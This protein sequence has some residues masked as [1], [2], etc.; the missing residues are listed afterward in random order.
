MKYFKLP[1]KNCICNVY[2]KDADNHT[3]FDWLLEDDDLKE[4]IINTINGQG[5]TRFD[6]IEVID[7]KIYLNTK[8]ILRVR[9]WGY[10]TGGGS[11]KL[12]A[13]EAIEEQNSV[14][15]FVAGKLRLN[16]DSI[17]QD[18]IRY[19]EDKA[20]YDKLGNYGDFYYKLKRYVQNNNS[21]TRENRD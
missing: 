13:K 10:L 18:V 20:I 2:I 8:P 15:N 17:I 9:G 6:R 21:R 1:F 7:D 11:L 3:V 19:C 14:L 5:E 12:P 4:K 16:L